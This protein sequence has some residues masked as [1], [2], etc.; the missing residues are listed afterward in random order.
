MFVSQFVL[1]EARD[2]D[3]DAAS[4]RITLLAEAQLLH[5]TENAFLLSERLIAAA[6][7]PRQAGTDA[8]HIAMAAVHGLEFLLTW[9]CR[10]IANAATRGRIQQTCRSM[11]YA[12]PVLCTPLELMG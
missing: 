7:V 6:V 12:T 4:R 3:R 9:N 10:H 11:R 5:V 1:E 8:L 2:G